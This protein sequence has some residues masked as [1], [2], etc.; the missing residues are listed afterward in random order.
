MRKITLK[1]EN[2]TEY[3]ITKNFLKT[4][5]MKQMEYQIKQSTRVSKIGQFFIYIY[6]LFL[7]FCW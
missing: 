6:V 4:F 5:I 1:S 2:N 3:F 7:L